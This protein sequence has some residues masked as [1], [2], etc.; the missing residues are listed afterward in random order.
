MPGAVRSRLHAAFAASAAQPTRQTRRREHH[1]LYSSSY[2][3]WPASRGHG[4]REDARSPPRGWFGGPPRQDR[5][6]RKD[7]SQEQ[8]GAEKEAP[9]GRG[10]RLAF[11]STPA[12]DWSARHPQRVQCGNQPLKCMMHNQL[13]NWAWL[14]IGAHRAPENNR[15]LFPHKSARYTRR[16]NMG[17]VFLIGAEKSYLVEKS[18]QESLFAY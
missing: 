14:K 13:N 4:P 7:R 5:I 1:G 11:S 16:E 10:L 15:P 2:H 9:K 17:L 6:E 8:R 3:L 12:S 18:H